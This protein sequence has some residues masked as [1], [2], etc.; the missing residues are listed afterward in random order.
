MEDATVLQQLGT[1][2]GEIFRFAGADYD[3][4]ILQEVIVDRQPTG[5]I[6]VAGKFVSTK[7]DK[8]KVTRKRPLA[9]LLL[10][11]FFERLTSA[12]QK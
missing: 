12:H 4:F 6:I 10:G 1:K 2:R 8:A 3:A 9:C 5:Q 7:E 11:C